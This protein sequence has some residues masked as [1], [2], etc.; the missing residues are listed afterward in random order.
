MS[1]KLAVSNEQPGQLKKLA[2]KFARGCNIAAKFAQENT[3]YNKV[4]LHHLAYY[5]V[6]ETTHL[7]SQMACNTMRAVCSAYESLKSN[8]RIKKDQ[9][10]PTIVFGDKGSVH[11]DKRT[12]SFVGDKLSLYTLEGRIRVPMILGDHQAKYLA[13]G[14]PKEAKLVQKRSGWYFNLVLD[15]K[16]TE[17]RSGGVLGVDLGENVIATTSSGKMFG[18]GKL[19][20]DRDRFLALRRRLQRNGSSSAKQLL[21]KISGREK[22]HV[23][24]VNHEVSKAIIDEALR[25]GAGA[26]SLEKLTNIRKRIKAGK[27]LRARLHRWAWAQLQE[28]IEYKAEGAG[29][30]VVFVN[31]AYSS[32]TCHNCGQIAQRKKHSL[33]CMC[34][35]QAHADVNAALN[36]AWL[37]ESAD[38]AR[39]AVNHPNV[40]A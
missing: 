34:G 1:I 6:R 37:A 18:G 4:K 20:Y 40:A 35:N 27:K 32:K 30:K 29:L 13:S 3:T 2:S 31:P 19:R 11:F 5:S 24:H 38:S 17:P 15:I 14:T 28:F 7:G 33:S 25:V 22:R 21:K 23:T 10:L 9:P 16:K 8:K 26:I 39:G 12:Y 36:I